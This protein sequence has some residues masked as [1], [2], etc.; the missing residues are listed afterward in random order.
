MPIAEFYQEV[1]DAQHE[2]H[3][4]YVSTFVDCLLASADY[5]SFYKVM[6][7][8]GH[9]SASSRELTRQESK[10]DEKGVADEKVVGEKSLKEVEDD[11]KTETSGLDESEKKSYK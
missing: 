3:D 9:R 2:T 1:R 6:A 5:E 4:L 7:K 11:K 10:A 8:E